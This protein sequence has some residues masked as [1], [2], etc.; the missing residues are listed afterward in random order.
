MA[1]KNPE[2]VGRQAA[3]QAKRLTK[4]S[5]DAQNLQQRVAM[6]AEEKVQRHIEWA[7]RQCNIPVVVL[8]G[9]NTY[10]N[11]GQFLRSFGIKVSK[12][13]DFENYKVDSKHSLECEHDIVTIALLPTGPLVIFTQVVNF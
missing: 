6:K 4:N 12:L 8:R 7:F 9:I 10:K 2:E 5:N 1:R 13:K 11:I 3:A